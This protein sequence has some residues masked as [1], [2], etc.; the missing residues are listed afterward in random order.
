MS[1]RGSLAWLLWEGAGCLRLRGLAR[2]G[3][4][5]D[6]TAD[7]LHMTLHC[8]TDS[9]LQRC[10]PIGTGDKSLL[11]SFKCLVCTEDSEDDM[12]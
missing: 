7:D 9:S 8:C 4:S 12:A 6:I 11:R 10:A 5:R 3:M 1:S 2:G